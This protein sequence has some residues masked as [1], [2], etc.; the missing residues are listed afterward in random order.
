MARQSRNSERVPAQVVV[1]LENGT[2]GITRDL[3]PHGV[4]FV[5]DEEAAVGDTLSFSIEFANLG[6]GALNLECT[7]EVVR[8]EHAP[9]GGRGFA[10]KIVDSRLERGAQRDKKR[11]VHAAR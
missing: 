1:R 9:G 3:S 11:A 7:G 6:G 4:F 8:V 10:L 5:M 2:S